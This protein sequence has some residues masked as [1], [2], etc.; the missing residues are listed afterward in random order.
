[1]ACLD[2]NPFASASSNAAHRRVRAVVR[3]T[4]RG[5]GM[6]LV[7][8]MIVV[9][10]VGILLATA[11]PS[12]VRILSSHRAATTVNDLVHAIAMTRGEALKRGRRVY[13]APRGAHWRDGW[14]VFVDRNDNRLFD[15]A[16][17]ETLAL[18][19]P[20]GPT[21]GIVN[22]ANPTRESF[23]DV[24][25]PQRTYIMF[26]GTGYARQRNGAFNA[27]SFA[28]TDRSGGATTVRT[29]CLAAYGRV[30]VVIDH[31]GCS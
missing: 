4:T 11:V 24:G 30:R 16:I 6:S 17:D 12:F 22:S 5:R 26:D 13:L 9:S 28:I 1:M 2:A 29:I 14:V 10:I 18:H 3:V 15:P 20:P 7:E 8:S 19:D 21:I 31:A 25:T 27:G 23:T